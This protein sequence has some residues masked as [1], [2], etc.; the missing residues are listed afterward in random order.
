[1]NMQLTQD[2]QISD[3]IPDVKKSILTSR[4]GELRKKP[5]LNK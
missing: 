1:M 5:M 3:K 2:K 4:K